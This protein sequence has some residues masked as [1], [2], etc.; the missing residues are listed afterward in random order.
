MGWQLQHYVIRKSWLITSVSHM[1]PKEACRP[2]SAPKYN[3]GF[4]QNH[5]IPLRRNINHIIF[6]WTQVWGPF[7]KVCHLSFMFF[8][9]HQT[10]KMFGLICLHCALTSPYRDRCN[11][12]IFIMMTSALLE[13]IRQWGR[14]LHIHGSC[15]QHVLKYILYIS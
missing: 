5:S 2:D 13:I 14:F 6:I 9:L 12:V 11:N 10:K 4:I 8:I 15:I 7:N 3:H 1:T